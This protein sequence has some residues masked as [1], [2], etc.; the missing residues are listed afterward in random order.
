MLENTQYLNETLE[1]ADEL[2]KKAIRMSLEDIKGDRKREQE[3]I[4]LWV[5]YGTGI[6]GFFASEAE[7]TGNRQ[8]VGHIKKSILKNTKLF[9]ILPIPKLW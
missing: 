3:Y 5:K 8:I 4:E 2:I 6:G 9:S 7:R 1:T